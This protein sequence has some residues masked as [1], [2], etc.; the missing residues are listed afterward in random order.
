MDEGGASLTILRPVITTLPLSSPW[1]EVAI[2]IVGCREL[3]VKEWMAR[4]LDNSTTMTLHRVFC[5]FHC[6]DAIKGHFHLEASPCR[7]DIPYE[8]P[9]GLAGISNKII[10]PRRDPPERSY[11]QIGARNDEYF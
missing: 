7:V 8:K 6:D 11:A 5:H 3:S 4:K 10:E 2:S 9:F 1:D